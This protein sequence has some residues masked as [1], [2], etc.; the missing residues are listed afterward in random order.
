M[1]ISKLIDDPND[2]AQDTN[3]AGL[4]LTATGGHFIGEVALCGQCGHEQVPFWFI[5][6]VGA[7]DGTS[8]TMTNLDQAT[9]ANLMAGLYIICDVGTD[10]GKYFTIATNTA[11]APTVITPTVAPNADCDGLLIITNRLPTGYTAAS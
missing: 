8:W 9:T 3:F 10:A 11:A 2:I 5:H 1:Y 6:D 4:L 7:S